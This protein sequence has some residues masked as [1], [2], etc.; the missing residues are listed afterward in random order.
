ML[1]KTC[2]YKK[3]TV[4]VPQPKINFN[5]NQSYCKKCASMLANLRNK[6][7]RAHINKLAQI[8]YNEN[9]AVQ[10]KKLEQVKRWAKNNPEKVKNRDIQKR[11]KNPTLYATIYSSNCRK[12]QTIKINRCPKWLTKEQ[13]KAM[14]MFYM[15]AKSAS[16]GLGIA[17]EVDHIVPLQGKNVSGLHVPWNLQRIPRQDNRSKGNRY[18]I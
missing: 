14:Q 6:A 1:V 8:R 3:C 5:K 18:G 2:G 17:M 10:V 12:Y 4:T 11:L 9:I 16:K 13:L 7:N 15:H